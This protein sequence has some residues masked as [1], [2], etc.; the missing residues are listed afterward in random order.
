VLDA[1][2][3]AGLP[4]LQRRQF[5]G[6]TVHASYCAGGTTRAG[7]AVSVCE[8]PSADAAAA[9]KAYAD[10]QFAALTDAQRATRGNALLTVVG[11]Q[12]TAARALHAFSTL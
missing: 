11:D 1:I 9:G 2:D 6:V 7:L 3:A 4:V 10:R 5:L 12:S 8:Y